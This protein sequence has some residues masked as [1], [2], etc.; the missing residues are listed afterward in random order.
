M[1]CVVKNFQFTELLYSLERIARTEEKRQAFSSLPLVVLGALFFSIKA[2][3][4]LV[5]WKGRRSFVLWAICRVDAKACETCGMTIPTASAVKLHE[6]QEHLKLRIKNIRNWTEVDY[7]YCLDHRYVMLVPVQWELSN[8]TLRYFW[9]RLFSFGPSQ[10]WK[11][12]VMIEHSFP[13]L[14][15]VVINMKVWGKFDFFHYITC[16]T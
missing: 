6:V 4:Y 15:E 1:S 7:S 16:R 11:T 10:V 13:L 9:A 14:E 3:V 5:V 8:R 2:S 12:F